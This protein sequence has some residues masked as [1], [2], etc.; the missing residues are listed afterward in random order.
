MPKESRPIVPE[1]VYA[2][3]PVVDKD[4]QIRSLQ[5]EVQRLNRELTNARKAFELQA[6]HFALPKDDHRRKSI[7]TLDKPDHEADLIPKALHYALPAEDKRR[8]SIV[9]LDKDQLKVLRVEEDVDGTDALFTCLAAS[10][11][12]RDIDTPEA[13]YDT[14]CAPVV[15][16]SSYTM[17]GTINAK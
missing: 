4:D 2:A 9:K 1:I 12:S 6:M 3:E 13:A 16:D 8:A 11:A 15:E 7:I 10:A 14:M 17:C 5:D